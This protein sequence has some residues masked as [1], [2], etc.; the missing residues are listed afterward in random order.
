MRLAFEFSQGKVQA[1]VCT[2]WLEKQAREPAV[3]LKVKNHSLI[4]FYE[5]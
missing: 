4:M 3:R 1:A 2:T 5:V